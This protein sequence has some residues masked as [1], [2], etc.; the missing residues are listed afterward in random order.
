MAFAFAR[1]GAKL[2]VADLEAAP[3]ERVADE[4]NALGTESIAVG[5]DIIDEQDVEQLVKT[6]ISAFGG[7]NVLCNIAG[8]QMIRKLHET[9][10]ADVEW[11][12]SVNVF[13]L[14]HSV[15]HSV[16][17]LR[18]AAQRGE[19]ARI[20]NASSGFGI[21]L[22]PMGPVS[23]SAYAGTKHAI[24]GLSDAMRTELEDDGIGVSVVCPGVVNTQTWTSMRFRHD[25][26]G[27]PVPGTAQSRAAVRAYGQNP[28]ETAAMIIAGVKRGDFYILPLTEAGKSSMQHAIQERYEELLQALR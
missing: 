20:V 6:A 24:V 23:P 25:R 14:C 18:K 9:S 4:L 2:I 10:A 21:A 8:V 16:P 12:F 26:F 27:G 19:V 17:E 28:D 13:G 1:E 22:P 7:I 5:C 11:L 15:R 3:A